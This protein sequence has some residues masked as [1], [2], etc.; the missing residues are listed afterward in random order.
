[1]PKK[2]F[3]SGCYD[4]L[5]SGHVE[6][7]QE[8]AKFGDL[9]VALGSDKTVFDLKGRVPVNHEQERLFMVKSVACVKDA[10]ISKGSGMLDFL[11]ELK[12]IKPDYF[13]V[14]EDGNLLEKKK[15]CEELGIEYK[16][17]KR[18][19]HPGLAPR[20]TTA[21]RTINTIPFRIDV[22]GGWLDQPFV[23]K[24]YPGPVITISLEPTVDFNDRSGMASSTRRS[25]IDLWGPRLPAGDPEKLAKILFCYDNPPGTKEIS[26][27]QDAI[28]I[29]FPGLNKSWYEGEYWPSRIESVQDE[30][31]L[32]F[33]EKSL[34][35]IPLGPR[36][37][38]FSVLSNTCIDR[39][40]AKDLS[41][42][43]E[44][45][46]DAILRRDVAQ[47]GLFLRKA[48]EGQIAMFP[49][50]MNEMVRELI[51]AYRSQALGWKLSGA[52]GGGYLIFVSEQPIE[53]SI[54]ILIRRKD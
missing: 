45:C 47:F 50:M 4:L 1:M 8:A 5:H 40:R 32:Q 49:N 13:I 3:V 41:E 51:E 24:F 2:V 53:N 28:G 35:L 22:A 16:I 37:S 34:N 29:V 12:Q 39:Q 21:L 27:S 42:A 6:F 9:Y 38:S 19:P 11:E 20:S 44:N 36:A 14:N 15:L 48:F 33:I 43:A 31:I 18:E 26:G 30:H 25:A 52:G 7:F 54:H 17:L 46:W 10:F 23:S